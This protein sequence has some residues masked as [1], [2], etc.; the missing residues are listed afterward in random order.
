MR[1]LTQVILDLQMALELL[2]SIWKLR[3]FSLTPSSQLMPNRRIRN[4][5]SQFR[6][7]QEHMPSQ[8]R[9]TQDHTT[10]KSERARLQG[11][12]QTFA[13]ARSVLAA[14]NASHVGERHPQLHL[15]PAG[16]LDIKQNVSLIHLHPYCLS[17]PPL[18]LRQC[19][20]SFHHFQPHIPCAS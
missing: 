11:T 14:A 1:N 20:T 12:V 8:F 10:E 17:T 5:T 15:G 13:T 6:G 4:S 2:L 18:N 7:T 16:F 3:T 19:A 9:G